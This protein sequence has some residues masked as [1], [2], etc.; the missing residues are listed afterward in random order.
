MRLIFSIVLALAASALASN[1]ASAEPISGLGT[2]SA[3]CP[4]WLDEGKHENEGSEL[5]RAM[6]FGMTEWAEGWLTAAAFFMQRNV[7]KNHSGP[8]LRAKIDKYCEANPD[9]D[10]EAAAISIAKEWAHPAEDTRK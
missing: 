6:R 9:R 7:L 8:E 5:G 10:V 1:S 2:G 3:S 4:K